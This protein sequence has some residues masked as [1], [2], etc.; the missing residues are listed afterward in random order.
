MDPSKPVPKKYQDMVPQPLGDKQAYYKD[1]L[2][3]CT[4]A[5]GNKGKR[6]IQTELDR[7]AMTL[8]QPQSMQNYVS[9]IWHWL[10]ISKIGRKD[11]RCRLD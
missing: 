5:F 1:F 8:R 11:F 4:K 9:S 6:C 2:E 7:V 3:G 10:V